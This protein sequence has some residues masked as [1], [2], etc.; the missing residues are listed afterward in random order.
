MQVYFR[1]RICLHNCTCSRT[2]REV[3]DQTCHLT[4]SRYADTVATS[5]SADP[6]T[7]VRVASTG[8]VLTL[9]WRS[10]FSWVAF[11]ESST[12]VCQFLLLGHF[13]EK[14]KTKSLPLVSVSRRLTSLLCVGNVVHVSQKRSEEFLSWPKFSGYRQKWVKPLV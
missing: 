3:W 11:H 4:R 14:S 10:K 9:F 1:E 7:P 8:T 12:L 6:V 13:I 2:E 5:P